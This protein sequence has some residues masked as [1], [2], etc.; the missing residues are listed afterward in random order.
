MISMSRI[1]PAA[2][3][4]AFA[5]LLSMSAPA[6][7]SAAPA[8]WGP[9]AHGS[10][11]AE[12][13]AD[14]NFIETSN[15]FRFDPL[16]G[17]PAVPAALAAPAPVAGNSAYYLV[18]GH[19]PLSPDFAA[20]IRDA[21]GD[22]VSFISHDAY[23]VRATPAVAAALAGNSAV[24]WVG[25]YPPAFRLASSLAARSGVPEKIVVT[26]F[27]HAD[28]AG[29]E[30][31]LEAMGATINDVS[32]TQWNQIIVAT[33]DGGREADAAR[34]NDV[35]WIEPR[36]PVVA[37]NMLAQYVIQTD[38]LNYRKVWDHGITGR[39][40]VGTLSDTGIRTDNCFFYDPS[41]PITAAGD[42]PTHRKI[43]AYK[44]TG[45]TFGDETGSGTVGHGSH[46][47]CTM[48]GNDSSASGY[49]GMAKD[50]KLY[51]TDIG[52]A[53]G[54]LAPPS[55]LNTMFQ[56]PYTG[57]T[58]GAARISSNSWGQGGT[59][60]VYTTYSKQ[61]DQFMWNHKDFL[62]F[63]SDGNDGTAGSVHSPSTAKDCISGGG[64]GN[65]ISGSHSLYGGTS[66][67]PC[68]DG[69]EADALRAGHAHLGEL[70]GELRDQA[71][72]RHQHGDAVSRR[73]LDPDPP[74]LHRRLLPHR[75]A[76]AHQLDPAERGAGE[77]D[78]REQRRQRRQRV[79]GPRQQRRL[80]ADAP[81]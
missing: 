79:H 81:R 54:G 34:L 36:Y 62:I 21:G 31:A 77:G 33:L 61:V 3:A 80:G 17:V 52:I 50:A 78:G 41:V 10:Y 72:H 70:R 55:D 20:M 57:N 19:A 74:V 7:S 71:P 69:R 63:F 73:E 16:L 38:S 51:F 46:T 1:V 13:T 47:N 4:T 56:L 65:D 44:L 59:S 42:F 18:Q 66:R 5:V 30:S 67:G 9:S 29:V 11:L 28:A 45:G 64:T 22:P 49:D 26:V 8:V 6:G 14:D 23:V 27:Q 68:L 24:R 39:G 32:L 37:D 43:I 40:Q 25:A 2:G 75:H 76:H 60:G 15:G 58:G 12:P 53:G 48:A 35:E